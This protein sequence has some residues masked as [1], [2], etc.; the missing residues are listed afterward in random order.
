VLSHRGQDKHRQLVGVRIYQRFRQRGRR[1]LS[2][3]ALQLRAVDVPA[4]A[5][6]ACAPDM[7]AAGTAALR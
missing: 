4:S 6:F 5:S 2:L 3:V 1:P 7:D